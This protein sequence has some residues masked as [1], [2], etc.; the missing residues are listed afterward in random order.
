MVPGCFSDGPPALQNKGSRLLAWNCSD[1]ALES[2][3]QKN[4][5]RRDIGMT[6]FILIGFRCGPEQSALVNPILL[7]VEAT[8]CA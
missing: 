2:L 3:G 1:R 5:P 4:S 6:G 7:R 8:A